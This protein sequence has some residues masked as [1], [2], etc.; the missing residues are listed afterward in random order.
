MLYL[1][2]K[3][4]LKQGIKRGMK[5][6]RGISGLLS[7]SV[8][9]MYAFPVTL[10]PITLSAKAIKMFQVPFAWIYLRRLHWFIILHRIKVCSQV[11]LYL[12]KSIITWLHLLCRCIPPPPHTHSSVCHASIM[13]WTFCY[14]AFGILQ[15]V[16]KWHSMSLW[17]LGCGREVTE[18]PWSISWG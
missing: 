13:E 11:L 1:S 2:N 3:L 18:T 7:R 9:T 8:I 16:W 14:G 5:W 6:N 10:Q 12:H 17:S 4:L 15:E